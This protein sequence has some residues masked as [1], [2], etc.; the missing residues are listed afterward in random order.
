MI[1]AHDEVVIGGVYASFAVVDI[2]VGRGVRNQTISPVF[3]SLIFQCPGQFPGVGP[4]VGAG[5]EGLGE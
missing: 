1:K 2:A 3:S 5:G 4:L